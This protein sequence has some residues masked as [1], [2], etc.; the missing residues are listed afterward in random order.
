[1]S[2]ST[3]LCRK[4]R[5]ADALVRPPLGWPSRTETEAAG[6]RSREAAGLPPLDRRWWR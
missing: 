5:L 6:D 4:F 1:M 2:L 3:L